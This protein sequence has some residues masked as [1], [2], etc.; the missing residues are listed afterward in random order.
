MS[1]PSCDR[2]CIFVAASTGWMVGTARDETAVRD[3]AQADLEN[4]FRAEGEI[5]QDLLGITGRLLQVQA[6]AQAVRADNEV[7]I[8]QGQLDDGVPADE[9]ALPRRHFLAHHSAM[10]A[11]EEMH[12][13]VDGNGVGAKGG[14]AIDFGAL[15]VQ[16][17]RQTRHRILKIAFGGDKRRG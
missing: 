17:P 1:Q 3:R 2:G 10:A 4:V 13:P 7:V 16:K 8:G 6:L 5:A 11:T 12:E 9:A 14:G 15:V